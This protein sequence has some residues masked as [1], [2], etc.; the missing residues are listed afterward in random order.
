MGDLKKQS[1]KQQLTFVL[2]VRFAAYLKWQAQID[3]K[4][5]DRLL[6]DMIREY[7]ERHAPPGAPS[8]IAP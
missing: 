1:G 3:G 6:H 4:T 5:R 8:L 7:H 2:G